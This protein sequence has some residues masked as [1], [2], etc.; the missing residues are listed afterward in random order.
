MEGVQLN[1]LKIQKQW[2]RDTKLAA[3]CIMVVGIPER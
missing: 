1:N 3:I 2:W